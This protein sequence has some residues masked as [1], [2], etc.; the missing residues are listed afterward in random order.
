MTTLQGGQ[1]STSAGLQ[2]NSNH[3]IMLENQKMQ[4]KNNQYAILNQTPK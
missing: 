3:L 2:K 1:L 4:A